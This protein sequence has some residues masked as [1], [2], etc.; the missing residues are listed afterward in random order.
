MGLKHTQAGAFRAVD[1]ESLMRVEP[2]PVSA[3]KEAPG[4]NWRRPGAFHRAAGVST[5]G[6]SSSRGCEAGEHL[7]ER[8]N[9]A[10]LYCGCA[11]GGVAGTIQ[12]G[13]EIVAATADMAESA[14]R[15]AAAV[16]TGSA[17]PEFR[18]RHEGHKH[19]L[20]AY[21]PGQRAGDPKPPVS[22]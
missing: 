13:G 17:L 19:H 4:P 8:Q 22:A 15:A 11:T 20:A 6:E 1:D 21:L 5:A 2:E 9:V 16:T 7:L 18:S 10:L 3:T 14:A 12:A